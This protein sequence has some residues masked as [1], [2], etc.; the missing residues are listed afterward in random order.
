MK[1]QMQIVQ[2]AIARL[3]KM[4]REEFVKSLVSVGLVDAEPVRT[5]IFSFTIKMNDAVEALATPQALDV[6]SHG[7][8]VGKSL[9][10]AF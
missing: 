6:S 4:S 5:E 7:V 2:E 9:S 10:I 3:E 1:T 8:G